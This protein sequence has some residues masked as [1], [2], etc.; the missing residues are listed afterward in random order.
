MID[1]YVCEDVKEQRE[2]IAGY[3]KNIILMR[4]Y[5]M[6]LQLATGSPEKLIEQLKHTKNT[7]IY[8]LDIDLNADKDGFML[9]NE[10]REYDSRG[11]IVFIT[12]HSEMSPLTFQY[13]VEALDFILKEDVQQWKNRIC[14]CLENITQ[15][16]SRITRGSGKT[17]TI[18]KGGRKLTLAYDDILYFETSV[19]E[20]KLIAHTEN[21]S[22][23]FFGKVKCIEEEVGEDFIRCH[24]AYL[25]N[26]K[27][28]KEVNY[29]DKSILMKNGICCPISHRML[30]QVKNSI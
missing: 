1:V 18:A 11:F 29:A 14:E 12:S 16:Y 4:E 21:K 13:K 10:I 17:I 30:R 5:D 20:H 7:G 15:K 6:K 24:R 27:N 22:I 25:V 19:N 9:A 8:F 23:E 28:I 3:I 2:A 26:K